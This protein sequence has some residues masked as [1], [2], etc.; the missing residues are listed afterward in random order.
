MPVAACH[1]WPRPLRYFGCSPR[2]RSRTWRAPGPISV[3]GFGS[4]RFSG[5][6]TW[7]RVWY[8]CC[9]RTGIA[10]S[11][12]R[13]SLMSLRH[14]LMTAVLAWRVPPWPFHPPTPRRA[15]TFT[16]TATVKTAGGATAT[17]P[18]TIVVD[19]K[20]AQSEADRL[21]RPSRRAGRPR[22][23]R[24]SWAFRPPAPCESAPGRRRH[25]G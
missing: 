4:A 7:Q 9:T 25:R 15:E 5:R 12:R 16:A 20:M 10:I 13:R 19:R 21:R 24:R 17:T 22:C 14:T 2:C 3:Q 18:V 6:V 11:Q 1:G 23:A 8:A